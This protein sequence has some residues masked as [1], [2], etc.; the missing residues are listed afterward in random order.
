MRLIGDIGGTNARFA[1][2]TEGVL[3]ETSVQVLKTADYV[4]LL[5]ALKTYVQ[6]RDTL[7][8]DSIRIA[9]AGPVTGDRV[10]M[11]NA[12]WSFSIRD[13]THL[14]QRDVMPALQCL[15]IVNDFEAQALALPHLQSQ[16]LTQVGNA[17]AI[18]DDA[19]RSGYKSVI[20]PGTGF[21]AASI[22]A[23]DRGYV[24]QASEGGHASIGPQTEKELA[25]LGWLLRNQLPVTREE[26]LS[27]PGLER[28]HR[29]LCDID[30]RPVEKLSANAIV[31]AA[32]AGDINALATLDTFCALLG[33]AARDQA[34]ICGARGGVYISGGIVMHF[35]ECFLRSQFRARFE[36]SDAMA[37][38]LR[39]IP[40]YLIS[41]PY[42]GLIG[43]ANAN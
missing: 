28:L 20:G 11:T 13:L 34:L 5:D 2:S 9:I 25:I 40:T 23:V 26:L 21:G 18:G 19:T 39:K 17:A 15:R 43:A 42:T 30:A 27:G 31:D 32:H 37:D 12:N 38:Y 7:Q 33:T 41:T 3:L 16:H 22:V 1:L 29:A 36:D 24:V 35:V 6:A 8:I 10:E 4:S 14:L